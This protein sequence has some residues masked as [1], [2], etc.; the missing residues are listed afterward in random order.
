MTRGKYV[1]PEKISYAPSGKQII[2]GVCPS[3]SN[4]YRIGQKGLFKSK[5]LKDYEEKFFMQCT[6]RNKMIQGKFE[7]SLEVFYPN[8][9]SDLDGVLKCLLDCLQRCKAIKNDNKCVR[10]E[11]VK[12]LDIK[13]PRIEFEIREV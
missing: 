9:R 4:S 5:A 11:A 7:I 1:V 10:I 2:Y 3:K 13:N 8:E 6:L 12:F